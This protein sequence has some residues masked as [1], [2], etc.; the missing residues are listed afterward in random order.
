MILV[1][2]EAA[3]LDGVWTR[4]QYGRLFQLIN[5]QNGIDI[6]YKLPMV[7]NYL[8]IPEKL[9]IFMIQVFFDLKFVTIKDGVLKKVPDPE[10]KPL[11]ES[12]LYQQRLAKIKT[13]EDLLM[14]D[15]STIRKWLIS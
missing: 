10:N 5:Q 9:L 4:E 2:T 13:E 6:R 3:Y 8:Q 14:S 11:T 1:S 12:V 7:A 15:L